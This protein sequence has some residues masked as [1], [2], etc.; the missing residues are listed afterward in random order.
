MGLVGESGSGKSTVA[1]SLLGYARRGLTIA[2][3]QVD[4][5]GTSVLDL[6]AADLRKARGTL[7]SYVPQ[8]PTSGLNPSL[9]LGYQLAEAMRVHDMGSHSE[10][11]DDRVAALLDEVRL[12]A[13]AALL[14]SYPHQVSGG[15]AQRV[16]IA[17]AFACRPRVVVLDEPTTGL[18]VTT[19]RHIL[20]TIR[21]LTSAHD[22]SA[23][24][25]SHDLPVVAEVADDVAVMYAGRLVERAQSSVIFGGARH[26]Y[27]ARL[28]QAAP[29]PE[30]SGV[31]IG[32]DGRPPR[33]GRWPAGCGFVE[34]CAAATAECR[35]VNPTLE[36]LGDEHQVRCFHPLD[37]RSS[38]AT[39]TSAPRS[40]ASESRGAVLDVQ[41][42]SAWY[43]AK[44]TLHDVQFSIEAGKCVGIVGESGSG[45]TTL[46][47]CLAGL[48]SS[49]DGPVSYDGDLL[50]PRV[51]RRRPE[52][53]KR[54]QYI[55][56]NPH[57]SLNPRLTVGENV[58]EPLR[59]FERLPRLE[60]RRKV[61]EML[62]LVAL[63]ADLADRMP[64]QL[65]GGERQ[66]VA[67]ARALIVDPDLL[68]CDEITS[69]LDVS[70]QALVIEQLRELQYQRGL[71]MLF[72]THNVAVVRSIAQDIMVL[73][74]G[75]VVETG[76]VEQV[77]TA[78]QHPYTQ[79]LMADLPRFADAIA[80]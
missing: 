72:I 73:E 52:Q 56:Q 13:T 10:S 35:S 46:A 47:R 69:A 44:Q 49:W 63:G 42:L 22:V 60:R 14:K 4:I 78:P 64:E 12:P 3:G 58:E 23:V 26:P 15:Q 54:I 33:P 43:G 62:E 70:V 16:A 8:D 24:Y 6:S 57:A 37:S 36:L 80:G 9:T 19:Q 45:K 66:R 2:Q 51:Q 71:S 39:A 48:H 34:R 28:L 32:I 21:Q 5:A 41:G 77:I 40:V 17:M 61:G 74:Q 75:R 1:L 67:V 53:R 18:D 30:R 68:I 50:E 31:L 11:I 20:Q 7:I 79:Q 27:T 76:E 65:S 25:V 55:F 59:F 29:T 38:M